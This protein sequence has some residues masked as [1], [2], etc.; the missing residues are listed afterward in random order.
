MLHLNVFP[1]PLPP[2]CSHLRSLSRFM[3]GG[4]PFSAFPVVPGCIQLADETVSFRGESTTI[5]PS[6]YPPPS[7][8]RRPGSLRERNYDLQAFLLPGKHAPCFCYKYF[9]RG[10]WKGGRSNRKGDRSFLSAFPG[11]MHGVCEVENTVVN[12]LFEGLDMSREYCAILREM[13][14]EPIDFG[15]DD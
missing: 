9:F 2:L 14:S 6:F 5:P 12:N 8:S 10:R 3:L 7:P 1:S 15:I 11:E 13:C 4:P